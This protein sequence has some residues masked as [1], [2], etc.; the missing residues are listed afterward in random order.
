M[1]PHLREYYLKFFLM[2]SHLNS[3][4]KTDIKPEMLSGVQTG[5]ETHMINIICAAFPMYKQTEKTSFSCKD[6]STLTKHT[7]CW[8]YSTRDFKIPLCHI[9]PLR[10][11]FLLLIQICRFALVTWILEDPNL[12]YPVKMTV[13]CNF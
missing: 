2:T 5:N 12:V 11:I 7:G 8:T 6:D 13:Y 3:H 10:S 1:A 9:P 4:R